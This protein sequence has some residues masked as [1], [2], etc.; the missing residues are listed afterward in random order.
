MSDA[1]SAMRIR[2]SVTDES[3][4]PVIELVGFAGIKFI[5]GIAANFENPA[6]KAMAKTGISRNLINVIAVCTNYLLVL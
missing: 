2:F 5:K 4:M 1:A 3:N 6:K